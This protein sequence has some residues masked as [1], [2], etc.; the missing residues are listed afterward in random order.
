MILLIAPA[1]G[2]LAR[3]SAR[4]SP[5]LVLGLLR[6][7]LKAIELAVHRPGHQPAIPTEGAKQ[8]GRRFDRQLSSRFGG[9]RTCRNEI[10]VCTDAAGPSHRETRWAMPPTYTILWRIDKA[11]IYSGKLRLEGRTLALEGTVHARHPSSASIPVEDV[12]AIRHTCTDCE[13][14]YGRDTLVLELRSGHSVEIASDNG[15]NT[16]LDLDKQLATLAPDIPVD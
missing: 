14:L 15:A 3:L 8:L 11:P 5:K 7:K 12:A 1:S 16:L 10:R 4:R 9:M 2:R 13:A 6:A